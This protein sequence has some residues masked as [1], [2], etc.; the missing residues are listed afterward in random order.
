MVSEHDLPDGLTGWVGDV[1]GGHIT[2]LE[3]HVA[4]REA[5]VVDVTRPDGSVVEGFLRLE[6]QPLAD[7]PWSL[8]KETRI[9]AALA[10]TTVPVPAVLGRSESLS[11]TLF[12][13]V[14]GRADLPSV[15]P[16]QQRAVMEDFIGIVA[17]LHRLDVDGLGLDGLPRPT[18]SAECALGEVDLLLEHHREFL[19]GYR[20]PLLTFGLA[21]LRRNVPVGVARI[22]L[23]QGDTGPVNFMFDGD[24]VTA[25]ID[26]E[27]GH[28]G[29]P[30]EDLGNICV[31]EF[32]NP[33]GGLA[34][35]FRRYEGLSGIPYDPAA[36][37][38]YRVQQNIRG[39]IGIHGV[40]VNA[41]P[42]E[43]VAWYLAYRYVGDRAT[44]EALAEAMDVHVERPEVPDDS[45]GDADVLADA[46][47]WAIQHDVAPA[48]AVPFARSRLDDVDILVHCIDRRRR[49]GKAIADLELDDLTSLL[50]KRPPSL[51]EGLIQLDAAIRERIRD[52]RLHD[53]DVVRYLLRRAWR[54]EWLWAPAVALYP[55]RRWA[56]IDD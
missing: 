37:R 23:V 50:G 26:W 45:A 18:T 33:S 8:A 29:D 47:R 38:Y 11:A 30:M 32:W 55:G 43:S 42:R 3:R 20:D 4:R 19:A 27:L 16:A 46:A 5:W 40:T 44:C 21:W 49:H 28:L 51:P 7:D 52:R 9:I 41:H 22:S 48:V 1:A 53:D 39:M 10:T 13:R 54:D 15:E 14:A 25:V 34:G 31:R 2:R 36:A 12:E 35:L 56:P 6:R 24:H 17:E